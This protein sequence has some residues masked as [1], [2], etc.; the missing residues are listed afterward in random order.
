MTYVNHKKNIFI[1][2]K[3]KNVSMFFF[4]FYPNRVVH[5]KKSEDLVEI[6]CFLDENNK[7]M[8]F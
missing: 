8:I 1:K 5:L 3:N 6:L 4:D 2:N 7:K